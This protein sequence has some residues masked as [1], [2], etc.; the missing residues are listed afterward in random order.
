MIDDV[1]LS[2]SRLAVG[3]AKVNYLVAKSVNLVCE[4]K[5]IESILSKFIFS[6]D[7]ECLVEL[8]VLHLA[9]FLLGMRPVQ[10]LLLVGQVVVEFLRDVSSVM[11]M[12]L[13]IG[14][15]GQF[16]HVGVEGGHFGLH[17]V[18]Q[19]GLLHVGALH[20][21]R[22]F[23]EEFLNLQIFINYLALEQHCVRL[24]IHAVQGSQTHVTEA[25]RVHRVQS[26][27]CL[28]GVIRDKH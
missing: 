10:H 19:V 23:F 17:V 7:V 26:K 2:L 1:R 13:Q 4:Q 5:E 16:E 27:V 6:N 8:E 11:H 18:K 22:N 20:L 15:R 14:G 25:V 21:H 12:R 3:K 24:A 28:G 9:L